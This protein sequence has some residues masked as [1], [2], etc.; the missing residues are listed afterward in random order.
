MPNKSP[1][2]YFLTLLL[3]KQKIKHIGV[4]LIS[5]VIITL[6]SSVLFISSSLQ[7]TLQETIDA[8]ADFTVKRVEAGRPVTTP[9]SWVDQII[10]IEGVSDVTPRVHGRYFY[11]PRE[12]SFW[13][14]G[15]DFFDVQGSKALQRL[16]KGIDLKQFFSSESMIVGEGVKAFLKTHYYTDSFSF[17]TPQ[18]VFK[19]VKLYEVLP[20][21]LNLLANDMI[22]M[23]ID[24]AREIFGLDEDEVTDITFNVPNEAEWDNVISKL[25]LLAY[26]IRVVEKR[27][28]EKAY[29]NL[30][31][32]KGGIFLI[33]YIIALLTFMLILY[34]RY[35]MVYSSERKEIG[36]LRAVGWSIRD[37]LKLKF[38]ETL[39]LVITSFIIGVVLA[40]V[41][42]FILGAPILIEIFLGG[43]NLVNHAVLVP[44]IE[45]G[46]LGSLFLL[47]A[48]PFFAAVLIPSWRIAVI[49]PKEAMR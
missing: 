18:G 32:Y 8:Q 22:I 9:L 6:I 47:Y 23:P 49:P 39:I 38:Y 5:I 14:V 4:M 33:L 27:E 10:D 46:I 1:F 43:A 41:Y 13:I 42:V 45:F 35:S 28:V 2:L 26:D 25:H 44:V 15:I 20:G 30:Y 12:E 7:H 19:K 16:V 17:K 31:N 36:I 11:A 21:S 37:I 3:F 24:L 40:Y 34:Q 48:V 29:E